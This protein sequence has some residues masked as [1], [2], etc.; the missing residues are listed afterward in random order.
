MALPHVGP[1]YCFLFRLKPPGPLPFLEHAAPCCPGPPIIVLTNC[2]A[3]LSSLIPRARAATGSH[4]G[5]TSAAIS[6]GEPLPSLMSLGTV[7]T[8]FPVTVLFLICKL[9]EG[10]DAVCL[11][12]HW[13]PE[14]S[15]AY[16]MQTYAQG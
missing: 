10:S 4:L 13:T 16:G 5:K 12:D 14:P 11:H 8:K 2:P 9:H 15:S 1:L 6:H 3:L 7:G